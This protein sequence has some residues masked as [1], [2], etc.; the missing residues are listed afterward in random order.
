MH[1]NDKT[2]TLT[3]N[4]DDNDVNIKQQKSGGSQTATITLNGS[5]G[6][7]LDLTM[8]SNNTTGAGTYS[9]TNTC[10]TVGGCTISV[11]QD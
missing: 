1:N 2:L 4:N 10:N 3:L 11:T 8:G 6:T 7:D 9:L 5:Y